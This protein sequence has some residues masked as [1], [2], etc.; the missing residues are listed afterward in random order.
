MSCAVYGKT[1]KKVR[2]GIA[3]KLVSNEKDYLKWTSKPRYLLQ[4]IFE[5][6]LVA[7]R[8]SKVT[9]TLNKPTYDGMFTLDLIK[10]LMYKLHYDNIKNKYGNN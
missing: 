10:V 1:M 8:K 7:M 5:N 2:N 6:D 9:L 3:E 4:K